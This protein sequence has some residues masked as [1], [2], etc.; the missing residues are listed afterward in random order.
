MLFFYGGGGLMYVVGYIKGFNFVDVLVLVWVVGFLVFGCVCVDFEY[1]FDCMVN[2]VIVSLDF[3][4]V[5][6]E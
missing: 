3:V 5:V 2:V 1:C 4:L 6:F